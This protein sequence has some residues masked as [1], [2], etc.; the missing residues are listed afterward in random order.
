[1]QIRVGYELHYDFPQPRRGYPIH[2]SEGNPP[3]LRAARGQEASQARTS[4][5][6]R[7]RPT[8]TSSKHL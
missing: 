4:E 1:M 3:D 7:E 5:T 2:L 8:L 6:R